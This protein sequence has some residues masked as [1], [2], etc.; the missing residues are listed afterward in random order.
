MDQNNK[1]FQQR[2]STFSGQYEK[3]VFETLM[4][5]YK[6]YQ[7]RIVLLL[8]LGLLGRVSLLA[9][10]NVV[11][12]WVDQLCVEMNLK[13]CNA[14]QGL[15]SGFSS[16]NFI[17]LMLVMTVA[18]FLMTLLFRIGFSRLSAL[19]VSQIYDET[20]YRTSRFPMSFF[21]S[22]P[23]GRV[24]TRFSS[25]Y[26]NVFRLF[27]GPLA[28]FLSI[29]FD[30]AC[31]IVL[32]GV[33]NPIF[34][35]LIVVIGILN[36]FIYRFNRQRLRELRRQLSAARSPSL[37]HFAETA[38][39]AST[40]RSFLKQSVFFNRFA[41]L[42]Q[43]Y[44]K[45]K[46]VTSQQV[47]LFS[48]QM[49]TLT[50]ILFIVTGLL[51]YFFQEQAGISIGS[52]GIAFGFIALSGNTVQ[53]FFEWMTQFEEA[54]VGVERLDE[55]IRKPL[56]PG[57]KLPIDAKFETNHWVYKEQP[58]T[59]GL[60]AG[61]SAEV[62]FNHLNFRYRAELPLVLNDLNFTIK[63]GER[64]G[65][66][67]RTGSGKSSLIQALLYLYPVEEGSITI[68][69][70]YPQLTP[71]SKG[72]DLQTYR[73]SISFISQESILFTGTL[74]ENLEIFQIKSH[75]ELFFALE[76]VGLNDWANEKSLQMQ[77]E[78]NGRNLSLG[79]RQL[80]CMARCLLQNAPVIIMDEATSSVDPQS[81]EILV[82]ATE[83]FFV[84]RTQIIIAHRL[85][86]LKKCDR[87]LWLQNGHVKMI[88]KTFEV[89]PLFQQSN[90][91]L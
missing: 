46:F 88:G 61:R 16:E 72:F 71:E 2:E 9:N 62:R 56:E 81:E 91:S 37:A 69:G 65:I 63:A 52:L 54:M 67:G 39:G 20:T 11:G 77:I 64:F 50:A 60:T 18:G 75:K 83:E 19:A 43:L 49:N 41:N 32:M 30:L 85:S 27:G 21:D 10:T 84:G 26:G 89:L 36:Y 23:V 47:V 45:Q 22:T 76:Q 29:I 15:L 17:T 4:S 13:N 33:A 25:D 1:S 3:S 70:K 59:A 51:T 5:A 31:M 14:H 7:I 58:T 90:L 12:A 57:N 35:P 79:E 40:I 34:L 6:P 66:I 53:M 86:T 24:I 82:R 8:L 74:Q 68:D 80:I 28:E 44:L 78:E 73:N 55:Y 48:I 38:Q 42:D 87:I